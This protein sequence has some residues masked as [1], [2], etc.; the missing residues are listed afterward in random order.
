[1]SA[2]FPDYFNNES[3]RQTDNYVNSLHFLDDKQSTQV[4]SANIIDDLDEFDIADISP[5]EINRVTSSGL[6]WAD[7]VKQ[8]KETASNLK[9]CNQQNIINQTQ[10]HTT[11]NQ[12]INQ[13]F[14]MNQETQTNNN[15]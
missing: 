13:Q 14:Q 2:F 9:L 8:L 4:G 5:Q 3:Q 7:M 1:M 15:H 10:V 11:I 12:Q 6:S